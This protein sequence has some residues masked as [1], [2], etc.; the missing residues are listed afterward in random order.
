MQF[1]K[2][3]HL[4]SYTLFN[5]QGKCELYLV[6]ENSVSM[7][8]PTGA[9]R[10]PTCGW[11]KIKNYMIRKGYGSFY[12][13]GPTHKNGWTVIAGE[14]GRLLIRRRFFNDL[15]LATRPHGTEYMAVP[16]SE[17]NAS[18][19]FGIDIENGNSGGGDS[20]DNNT[21]GINPDNIGFY[22]D[23]TRFSPMQIGTAVAV[24][25]TLLWYFFIY[26]K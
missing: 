26:R 5:D 24:A 6:G 19:E 16:I 4:S 22:Y 10:K 20:N 9:F 11:R 18:S 25:V 15:F 21:S 12:S 13:D 1:I 2:H 23:E 17:E 7:V 3:F 14:P 8:I